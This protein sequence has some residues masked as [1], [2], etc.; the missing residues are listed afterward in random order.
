MKY[1]YTSIMKKI[2]LTFQNIEWFDFGRCVD[3]LLELLV[4]WTERILF[5]QNNCLES[6]DLSLPPAQAPQ[7]RQVRPSTADCLSKDESPLPP[8]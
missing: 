7:T 6:T 2:N 8:A 4:W 1:F 5:S 3:L